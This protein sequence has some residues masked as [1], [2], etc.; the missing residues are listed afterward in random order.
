MIMT[1]HIRRNN[2][3]P[4]KRCERKNP[5]RAEKPAN[6]VSIALHDPVSVN[7]EWNLTKPQSMDV[8][9]KEKLD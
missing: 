9:E 5:E 2:I 8:E 4:G 1:S 7:K 6:Q 3:L